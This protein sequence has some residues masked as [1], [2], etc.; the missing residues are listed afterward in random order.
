MKISLSAPYLAFFGDWTEAPLFDK[1]YY[2][3][4]SEAHDG[5]IDEEDKLKADY[6]AT[7][8]YGSYFYNYIIPLG[9]YLYDI[10]ETVFEAIPATEEHIAISDMLGTIDGISAVYAGLLRNAK[11][12]HFTITDKLTGEVVYDHYDYNANKAFSQGGSPIPYYDFLKINSQ[13]I[14][15]VNNRQYEFRMQGKLDY[16]E[17]GGLSTNVRNFFAFDFYLDNEAPIIKE[18]TYEKVYDKTLKKTDIT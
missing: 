17:D 13:K 14:G 4:E 12:M 15:L 16:G 5:S 8:P 6:F 9:T 18:A 7:T 11:E 3:V 1:T 10:D 2:E